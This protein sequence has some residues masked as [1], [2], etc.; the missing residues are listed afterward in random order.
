MSF[1]W[2][3]CLWFIS[4]PVSNY[5]PVTNSNKAYWSTNLDLDSILTLVRRCFFI[6]PLEQC[7][8]KINLCFSIG[9]ITF[10]VAFLFL[11][12]STWNYFPTSW[13]TSFR[14]L[15]NVGPLVMNFLNYFHL[16]IPLFCH[17]LKNNLMNKRISGWQLFNFIL[18]VSFVYLWIL[19]F[20]WQW[21]FHLV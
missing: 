17:F 3:S 13:R 2:C 20:L 21:N 9:I 5:I 12:A 15:F 7:C 16:K 4:A 19:L 6:C 1:C 18:K 11:L 8:I 10:L 14:N